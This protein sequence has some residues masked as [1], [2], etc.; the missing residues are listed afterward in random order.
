LVGAQRQMGLDLQSFLSE[1]FHHYAWP[2]VPV[3]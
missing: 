1:R 2:L 3:E